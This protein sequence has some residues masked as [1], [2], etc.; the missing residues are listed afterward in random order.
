MRFLHTTGDNSPKFKPNPMD[1]Q[2]SQHR[3]QMLAELRKVAPKNSPYSM[4]TVLDYIM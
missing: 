3:G 4:K 2:C 1:K